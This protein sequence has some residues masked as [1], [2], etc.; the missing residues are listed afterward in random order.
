MYFSNSEIQ[1][2]YQKKILT[3][4]YDEDDNQDVGNMDLSDMKLD[5]SGDKHLITKEVS[6]EHQII[7]EVG[8]SQ[9]QPE[10]DF[11]FLCGN[12]ALSPVDISHQLLTEDVPEPHRRQVS[13]HH[14]RDIPKATYKP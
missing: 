8:L 13:Q 7:K 2:E 6:D 3:L 4:V 10:T 11:F 9:T 5:Q 1:G 12:L 14:A